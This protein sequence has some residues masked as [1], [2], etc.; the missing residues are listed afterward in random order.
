MKEEAFV[1][2]KNEVDAIA[3]KIAVEP[4]INLK[5]ELAKGS[6]WRLNYKTIVNRAEYFTAD[7][8]N[9]F[10]VTEHQIF[11]GLEKIAVRAL[12]HLGN[13]VNEDRSD[14]L[15]TA[16]IKNCLNNIHCFCAVFDEKRQ[17]V[18]EN[19]KYE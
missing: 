4:E 7:M 9:L 8:E 14:A 16:F 11:E 2:A 6:F 15:D 17:I 3:A 5:I 13:I 1:L 19:R 10:M 12:E 18:H